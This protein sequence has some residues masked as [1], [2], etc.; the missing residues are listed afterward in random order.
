MRIPGDASS[1][2]LIVPERSFA[3]ALPSAQTVDDPRQPHCAD[4]SHFVESCPICKQACANMQ[5]YPIKK[6]GPLPRSFGM[7]G[8]I[9]PA[10]FVDPTMQAEP[11]VSLSLT[12]IRIILRLIWPFSRII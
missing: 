12:I 3:A 5:P 2:E 9:T 6:S 8:N 11:E 1:S 4:H 7:T 10:T